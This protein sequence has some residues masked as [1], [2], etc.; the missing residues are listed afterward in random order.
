MPKQH[1]VRLAAQQ[2]AECGAILRRG[3][4]SALTQRRARI[5]LAADIKQ[6]GRRLT[7]VEIAAA[8]QVTPRTVARVRTAFCQQGFA[9]ALRGRP[10]P[11]PV[12]PKLDAVAE[13]RLIALACTT[14][15]D[16]RDRWSLRLLADQVV[17]VD[18]IPPVSREL[19]RRTLKKTTSS[20]GWCGDG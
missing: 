12:P 4:S 10:R 8:V 19:I 3:R 15:P 7:D 11:R 17:L 16:G 14:P 6:E 20:P 2:R 5:L 13:A 9:V 1:H 18:G